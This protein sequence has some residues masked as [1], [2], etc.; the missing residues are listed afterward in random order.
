M[1]SLGEI[2]QLPCDLLVRS[3]YQARRFFPENYIGELAASIRKEG[4]NIQPILVRR[5]RTDNLYELIAGECRWRAT[6]QAGFSV[7]NGIVMELSDEDAHRISLTENLKRKDLN[8]IE[9][10]EGIQAYMDEWGATQ[11]VAAE[12]FN[13][14]RSSLANKV[15]LLGLCDEV[16]EMVLFGELEAGAAKVLV[17]L[18]PFQQTILARKAHSLQWS[19]RE[20]EAQVKRLKT[21]PFAAGDKPLKGG[22]D[23]DIERFAEEMA[24]LT[25]TPIKLNHKKEGRGELVVSYFSLEQLE[26]LFEGF[27]R[28]G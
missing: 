10:A 1:E 28:I 27:K 7:I 6:I 5:R 8:P 23:F 26:G 16:K 18:K 24:E 2:T 13:I 9:E 14:S 11:E 17:T 22:K 3:P 15:R 25:G 4:K 20:M 12:V 19:V 21:D